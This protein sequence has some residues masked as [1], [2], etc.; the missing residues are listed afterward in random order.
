MRVTLG[1]PHSQQLSLPQHVSTPFRKD[2][3]LGE[4]G[5]FIS[6]VDDLITT[7]IIDKSDCEIIWAKLITKVANT[8]T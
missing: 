1:Y 5:V 6:I 8:Y 3:K 2:R 7:E 4:G